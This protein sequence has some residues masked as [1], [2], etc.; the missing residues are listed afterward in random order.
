MTFAHKLG[1][2]L[3]LKSEQSYTVSFVILQWTVAG[4]HGLSGESVWGPVVFR[5]SSGRFAA[6]TTPSSMEMGER[7]EEFTGKPAGM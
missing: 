6:Q 7:V 4:H 5:V 3:T 2:V 1:I